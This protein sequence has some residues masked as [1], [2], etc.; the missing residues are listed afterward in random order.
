MPVTGFE[1][2]SREPFAG[3]TSFGDAGPYEQLRGS[4]TF[5]VDPGHKAN[6][7]IVDLQLA[8]RDEEGCVRFRADVTLLRP[9]EASAANGRLLVDLTNRGRRLAFRFNRAPADAGMTLDG[10]PG[11]GFLFRHGWSVLSLGWQHDVPKGTPLLSFDAPPALEDGRPLEGV[12][13]VEL[14]PSAPA[15]TQ[16]LSDRGHRPYRA[17]DLNDPDAYLFSR[18][19][20][21]GPDTPLPRSAWRFARADGDRTVPDSE[22]IYLESGFEPGK[23][24][25]LIY[26][27]SGAVVTGTSLLAIRDVA[28]F[29]RRDDASNP[30]GRPAEFAYAFGI[31]QT[32]RLLRQYLYDGMNL[33]Q[34]GR[35][36]YDGLLVDIGGAMR[37]QFNQRFGQPS[38]QSAPGFGCLY[39]FADEDLQDPLT[40]R[41]DGIL[42]RQRAL[43]GVPKVFYVNS[44]SEYWRGEGSLLH[45]DPTGTGDLEP[46]PESRIYHFAG[47]AHVSGSLIAR[48]K[49]LDGAMMGRYAGNAN[50]PIPLLRA[51]LL[52]LDAW[53]AEGREPPASR[54]ARA[55]DGTAV[56]R[57]TVLDAFASLPA[58]T[59]PDQNH[60]PLTRT[61]DLGPQQDQG[62]GRYPPVEG[63][64]YACL[65]PA[66]DIDGNEVAGIRLPSVSEPLATHTGW[67]PRHPDI[68]AP[69]QTVPL[70][71]F[72]RYFAVTKAG[73]RAA[74]D[75]RLAIEERY[76][77]REDYEGRVRARARALIAEGYALAEDEN[78]LVGD[79]MAGWDEAH[80][81]NGADLTPSL[82]WWERS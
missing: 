41:T 7:R 33:D 44:S 76:A 14:R 24:Y 82:I 48:A 65:V 28:T 43:G 70:M 29:L 71:G 64:A 11:D 42:R 56:S 63:D 16:L 34:D 73:R 13:M 10:H 66:I 78:V 2:S 61:V 35:Q 51:A 18:D 20:E 12:I 32:G 30:L 31:S 27:A 69:E 68:G 59:T 8:P 50:N 81:L 67:N 47:T 15:K 75:P 58:Q 53:A 5:A 23:L 72:S 45:I 26:R 4:M 52:N 36:A 3:G 25:Y 74:D 60:L 40:G 62:I 46:A 37:G 21:D 39:P 19:W 6:A 77:G 49:P 38:V 17:A 22:H 9:V 80:A 57:A 1:L 79:A 54:H 55:D